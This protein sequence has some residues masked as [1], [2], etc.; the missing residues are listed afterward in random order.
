MLPRI[1]YYLRT[2]K[3]FW[4]IAPG[5]RKRH[6]CSEIVSGFEELS[7]WH[8]H[9]HFRGVSP[10]LKT[11]C[12]FLFSKLIQF[13]TSV[14]NISVLPVVLSRSAS[15]LFSKYSYLLS[16]QFGTRSSL[17]IQQDGI[18]YW[19]IHIDNT[20]TKIS[21]TV[22]LIAKLRHFVSQH[23]LLNIYPTFI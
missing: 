9:Q 21:R 12:S 18:L 16:L 7:Q 4:M 6:V 17:Q 23:T 3:N 11:T 10:L 1:F 15:Q 19:K 14:F 13:S 20:A 2:A 22:G 8:P 5:W